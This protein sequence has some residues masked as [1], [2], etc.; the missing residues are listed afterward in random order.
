MEY[1][2]DVQGEEGSNG[3]DEEQDRAE[4]AEEDASLMSLTGS[5]IIKGRK[6]KAIGTRGG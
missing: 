1:D 3:Q 6:G 2:P 5:C 4:P